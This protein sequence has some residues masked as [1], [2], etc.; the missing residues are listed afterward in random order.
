VGRRW[1]EGGWVCSA[2]GGAPRPQRE[3]CGGGGGSGTWLRRSLEGGRKVDRMWEEGG[4]KVGGCA[5]HKV[6][7]PGRKEHAVAAAAAVAQGH[8]AEKVGSR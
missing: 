2:Q 1:A 6:V 3:R 7:P 5:W 8:V 4:Q